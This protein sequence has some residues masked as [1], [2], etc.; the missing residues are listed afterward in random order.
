MYYITN[1]VGIALI[2]WGQ[3]LTKYKNIENKY[4]SHNT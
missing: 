1:D 2:H 3:G 4:I